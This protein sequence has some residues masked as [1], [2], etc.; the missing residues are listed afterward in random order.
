MSLH[1]RKVQQGLMQVHIMRANAHKT[2]RYAQVSP[3]AQEDGHTHAAI[4]AQACLFFGY[5]WR[6][7]YRMYVPVV[8]EK[9]KFAEGV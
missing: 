2:S 3:G 7:W 6:R 5:C 1:V 9:R 8:R 4:A